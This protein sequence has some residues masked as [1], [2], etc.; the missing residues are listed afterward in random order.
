M[1]RRLAGQQPA[2][3]H[4]AG[5]LGGL[6]VRQYHVRRGRQAR[7]A[8]ARVQ[9]RLA[10]A[11]PAHQPAAPGGLHA[12]ARA[13]PAHV[14]AAAGAG[15]G[16]AQAV[17]S[18]VPGSPRA[19]AVVD[20]MPGSPRAGAV[21]D[22]QSRNLRAGAVVGSVPG[23]L[24]AWPGSA[25][26]SPPNDISVVVVGVGDF[27]AIHGQVG[28]GVEGVRH[29]ESRLPRRPPKRPQQ[30][31]RQQRQQPVVH[32]E[33]EHQGLPSCVV[34]PHVRLAQTWLGRQW[35]RRD[36]RWQARSGVRAQGREGGK[37]SHSI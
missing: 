32:T 24:R 22:R 37:R 30:Q 18:G 16:A 25:A 14:R 10:A 17:G 15:G 12:A 27:M 9:R 28:W 6:E 21:V 26:A 36:E 11:A 8:R 20:G 23:D 33:R 35:R 34:Y 2:P 19:G 5:G 7:V 3:Q 31:H 4:A 29:L 13:V 1:A